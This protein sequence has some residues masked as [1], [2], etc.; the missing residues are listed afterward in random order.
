MIASE[1]TSWLGV[2]IAAVGLVSGFIVATFKL[3]AKL[4]HLADVSAETAHLVR[5]HLG[6]N[7]DSPRLYRRVG[8]MEV[9][10]GIHPDPSDD[11]SEP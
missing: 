4:D 6:P 8:R 7:G 10:L 5:Y 9:Q 11:L 1:V 3:F 2:G